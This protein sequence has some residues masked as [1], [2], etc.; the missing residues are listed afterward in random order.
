[1]SKK[2]AF[3]IN[4]LTNGG[5][6]RVLSTIV[7][8]LKQEGYDVELICLEKENFYTI[9]N[10]IKVTYLSMNNGK[11][12][13]IIKMLMLLLF[14]YKLKKY[15]LK[16]NITIVQS[17]LF[18]ANYVNV[19]AKLFGSKHEVQLVSAV[20]AVAK[21]G[22]RNFSSR[23][24]LFLINN[25]YKYSDILIFKAKAMKDEYVHSFKLNNK[26]IVINNPIDLEIIQELKNN[27]NNC[28]FNF[29]N[30]K[31]YIL[32][33]GRF[34]KDKRQIDLI[35]AFKIVSKKYIDVEIIFLGDGTEK[36][37][38]TKLVQEYKLDN[39]IHFLGNVENP[40]Y[41]LSKVY[42]YISTSTSEGFPNTLVEAMSCQVPVIFTDCRTG[43]REILD[44]K[45]NS[46]NL[47]KKK[48]EKVKYGI[49]VPERNITEISNAIEIY[50]D[51]NEVYL[52]YKKKIFKRAKE[53][54]KEKIILKYKKVLN[55]D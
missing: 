48:L 23:I 50:L 14:G 5:A 47:L 2:I 52:S 27:S 36:D 31:K 13:S 32:S 45:N 9:D 4:S 37:Y 39:K 18:R 38:L 17:H 55:L 11:Q 44:P 43:P 3:L 53:F 15:I 12:N 21:Y 33:I 20:S 16:N 40:F 19:F 49:L 22:K 29:N 25:L 10:S 6:E 30:N 1:M 24:N 8:S 35:D 51:N 41:Y 54:S 46:N 28:K 7:S 42:L 26:N 34:H